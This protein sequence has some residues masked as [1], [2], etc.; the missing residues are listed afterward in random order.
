MAQKVGNGGHGMEDYSPETGKYISDGEPNTYYDNPEE[1][2]MDKLFGMS[3]NSKPFRVEDVLNEAY[4][5]RGGRKYSRLIGMSEEER[6]FF[7]D[8]LLEKDK[9]V[10]GEDFIKKSTD[11]RPDTIDDMSEERQKLRNEWVNS[12]IDR[13]NS[14]RKIQHGR[15]A[16]IIL[17]LPGSGKSS[18]SNP[19]LENNGAYEI[20]SD[21]FKTRYIPEF[22]SDPTMSGKT[23]REAGILA[24]DMKETALHEGAN[25]LIGKV[26]GSYKSIKEIVD[27]LNDYGYTI[28]IVYNDLPG[29]ETEKRNDNR[30][31][32]NMRK[33]NGQAR[34]VPRRVIYQ[35][36][37]GV[38]KTINALSRNDK[39]NGM[40]IYS[41]DV[42]YGEKPKH[43]KTIGN[44]KEVI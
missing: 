4:S 20:D 29:E 12:E 5:G 30:F 8:K 3:H 26:G 7:F 19:I 24:S 32:S 1:N 34:Y 10:Y 6:Q 41:N 21:I 2:A 13:Q 42:P 35:S 18:L 28:D 17:G 16:V 9:E 38:F 25:V 15:H 39:I 23:Q 33:G 40:L 31:M 43:L 36:E 37:Y 22:K 44:P 11:D 14:I 27:D